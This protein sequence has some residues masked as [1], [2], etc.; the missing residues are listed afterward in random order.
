MSVFGMNH[1]HEISSVVD[2]DV[3]AGCNHLAYPVHVFLFG[4]SV[5]REYVEAFMHEGCG[6]VVLGGKRIAACDVHFRSSL[7]ENLAEMCRLGLKMYRKRYFLACERLCLPEFFLESREQGHVPP[8]PFDFQFPFSP[9]PGIAYLTIHS[10]I[11]MFRISQTIVFQG[12]CI[13]MR[14][15]ANALFYRIRYP[16]PKSLSLGTCSLQKPT[17]LLQNAPDLPSA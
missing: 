7:R 4:G 10:T 9:E 17:G 5:Y 1:V 2:Y 8:H 15:K 3:R 12:D 13:L 11:I 14:A 16:F 6:N